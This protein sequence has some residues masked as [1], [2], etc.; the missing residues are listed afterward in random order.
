MSTDMGGEN[1]PDKN[2]KPVDEIKLSV[3]FIGAKKPFESRIPPATTVGAIKEAA[4]NEFDLAE[5]PTP[6]GKDQI[7]FS[8]FDGK[9]KL[10]DLSQSI[11][12]VAG[13]AR[14]VHLKLVKKIIQG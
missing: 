9:T 13:Q 6:D 2:L 7:T 4:L 14:S 11:G 1:V 5:G 8:L 10:E 3:T 12:A